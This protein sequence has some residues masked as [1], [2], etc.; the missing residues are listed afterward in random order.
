MSSE[1]WYGKY[2][3]GHLH[4]GERNRIK[5][6]QLNSYERDMLANGQ[7]PWEKFRGPLRP[8]L[9]PPS[10]EDTSPQTI[11]TALDG[12]K[13]QAEALAKEEFDDLAASLLSS[14]QKPKEQ[15]TRV[16]SQR[17]APTEQEKEESRLLEF[18]SKQ[19]RAEYERAD[20][21]QK[22]IIW[23]ANRR[24]FKESERREQQRTTRETDRKE[25][26]FDLLQ[27]LKEDQSKAHLL[28]PDTASMDDLDKWYEKMRQPVRNLPHAIPSEEYLRME[29][30]T[31]AY[32]TGHAPAPEDVAAQEAER[33]RSRRQLQAE[34]EA[35]DVKDEEPLH[36]PTASPP[37]SKLSKKRRV[38][39]R[40]WDEIRQN[41][42]WYIVF[43]LLGGLPVG[44]AQIWPTLTD[45][46]VPQWLAEHRWPSLTTLVAAWVAIA[47]IITLVIVVRSS[48]T[49]LR[50]SREVDEDENK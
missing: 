27:R 29:R 16:P 23:E 34:R 11:R 32:L 46:K 5:A 22:A 40:I 18:M 12:V 41:K 45:K 33:L 1:L 14:E 44:F 19:V 8:D 43:F 28:P 30:I 6:G 10:E 36:V 48:L 50:N 49:T 39:V 20:L 35:L 38:E 3:I 21:K 4:V 17:A 7:D 42:G 13:K 25:K 26:I 24:A 15:G 2:Y 31:Q 47:A 9:S 37:R